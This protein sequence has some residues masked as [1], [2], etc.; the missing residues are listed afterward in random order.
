MDFINAFFLFCSEVI[1]LD[2]YC[3][4]RG[5]EL[6]PALDIEGE[7]VDFQQLQTLI[8]TTRPCFP[9]TK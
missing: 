8:G 5:M 4:D 1:S 6:V 7:V 2:R 9:S 3:K